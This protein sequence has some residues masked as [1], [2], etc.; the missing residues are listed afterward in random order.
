[1][2]EGILVKIGGELVKMEK[3][4]YR[5]F[6][7]INPKLNSKWLCYYDGKHYFR[8]LKETHL[9]KILEQAKLFLNQELIYTANNFNR[10]FGFLGIYIYNNS[11]YFEDKDLPEILEIFRISLK[12]YLEGDKIPILPGYN[13]SYEK[14]D[15]RGARQN[16]IVGKGKDF[17][18]YWLTQIFESR[19]KILECENP[20]CERIFI[21]Y[22]TIDK[23]AQSKTSQRFCSE[24]CRGKTYYRKIREKNK[25]I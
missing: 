5:V 6:R 22:K 2:Q 10:E 21:P 25:V 18:F 24:S 3:V 20:N 13:V 17:L 11:L 8:F 12:T 4:S 16:V 1:M 15:F 19:V 23:T 7:R 9:D 14:R